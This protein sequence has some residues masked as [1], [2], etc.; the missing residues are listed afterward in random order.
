MILA[1]ATIVTDDFCLKRFDI[2]IDGDR[3]GRIGENL[4]GDDIMDMTGKYILPGFIDVHIHGARGIMVSDDK[5]DI[6]EILKF[7]ATQGVTGIALS[8]AVCEFENMLKQIDVAVEQE[9]KLVTTKILAINA[10]GPFLSQKYRGAME[11]KCILTPD[12]DKLKEMIERGK[13]L[14]KIVAVAPEEDNAIDFIEYA[15]KNGIT[16]SIGHTNADYEQT[17]QAIDAGATHAVHTFNA[18]RPFNHRDPGVIGALLT[19]DRINCEAICDYIHLNPVTIDII[20]KLKG[21]DRMIIVSDSVSAAGI[22]VEEFDFNGRKC[23]VEDGTVRL[24]DGTIC[25]SS[26]TLLNGVQHL[27]KRGVPIVD[28]VKMASFNPAKSIKADDNVGSI[29]VGKSADLVVLDNEYNVVHTFINGD[30]V[31]T[32]CENK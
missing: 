21:A 27:L 30:C 10:E 24:P 6:E 1:N 23:T 28:V 8:L 9:S 16:V 3:I 22:D 25:G 13:G 32:R 26:R 31:Y 17:I 18:M 19:D 5:P 29:T 11:E 4:K 20:Y 7:E 12:I 14:L 2:E 15:V